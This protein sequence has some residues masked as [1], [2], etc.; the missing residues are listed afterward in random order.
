MSN[1][2][3]VVSSEDVPHTSGP[4]VANVGAG[5]IDVRAKNEDP[6]IVGWQG[7]DDCFR[8]KAQHIANPRFIPPAPDHIANARL[9]AAAPDLLAACNAAL[10]DYERISAAASLKRI[11]PFT[12]GPAELRAAIA[13][14]EGQ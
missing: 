12:L 14:A 6:P 13:K 5:F 9:I 10:N 1:Q 7:F 2:S 4:W 3:W 11:H 8:A